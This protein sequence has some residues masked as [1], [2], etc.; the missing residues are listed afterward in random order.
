MITFVHPNPIAMVG[1]E[2]HVD[3][4]FLNGMQYYANHLNVRLATLHP[5]LRKGEKIVDR[6]SIPLSELNFDVAAVV[7]GGRSPADRYTLQ[8]HIEK[9]VM[10][11]GFGMGFAKI[12][13]RS[14]VPYILT[15]EHDL[16][17]KI[18]VANNGIENRVRLFSR[19]LRA[20]H[21]YY[22]EDVPAMKNAHSL[23]C[24]G[25]PVYESSESFNSNRLLYLDSRMSSEQIIS[26]ADLNSRIS[27]RKQNSLRLLYSGRYEPIKGAADAVKVAI[28]CQRLGVNV[29]FHAY[30]QGSL[31]NEMRLIAEAAPFPGSIF[32]HDAI[33]YPDLVNKSREFD[34]FVCCH[35]QNDPSCTYL[36]AMGSGL[37]VVGYDNKMLRGVVVNSGS[38][39]VSKLGSPVKVARQ[40]E[41]LA[42]NP[43]L[44]AEMSFKSRQFS[45]MHVFEREFDLRVAAIE[46][47]YA[48]LSQESSSSC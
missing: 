44:L 29:E 22:S 28:E 10:A 43:G 13:K 38:G 47:A 27:R 11:Y 46:R 3:R 9:S 37:P 36:E 32:I 35:L 25:Y 42:R 23:H 19:A 1:G 41:V 24:N 5:L 21:E 30:G 6:V 2:L 31:I 48:C 4:K 18:A 7:D 14:H 33:T 26:L 39:F 16:S 45:L 34:V 8:K 17:T 20:V 40:I 12:A 15:L